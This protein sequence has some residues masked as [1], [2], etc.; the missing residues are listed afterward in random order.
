MGPILCNLSDMVAVD[1]GEDLRKTAKKYHQKTV[2]GL[3]EVSFNPIYMDAYA[4]WCNEASD[5]RK[6]P[7]SSVSI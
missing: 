7:R 1:R 6:H 3:K 5:L 2:V 4:V